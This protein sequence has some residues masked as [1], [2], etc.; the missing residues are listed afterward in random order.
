MSNG[1]KRLV[2]AKRLS[3]VFAG[4]GSPDIGKRLGDRALADHIAT[5]RLRQ[6]T[7]AHHVVDCISSLSY[8]ECRTLATY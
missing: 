8:I 1:R 3:L 6:H 5:I 2:I 4:L 7:D